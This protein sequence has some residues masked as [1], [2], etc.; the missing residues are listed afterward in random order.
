MR[1]EINDYIV[2]DSD[3]CHGKPTFKDTRIMISIVLEMLEEG[4]PIKEIIDAYPDLTPRHV[5]EALK[6]AAKVTEKNL[7]PI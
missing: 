1:I 2:I 5:K 4:A 3:I 7:L 6:F